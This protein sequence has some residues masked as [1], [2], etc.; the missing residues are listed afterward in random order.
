MGTS[1]RT[2]VDDLR[3]EDRGLQNNAFQYLMNATTGPVD[4]SYEIWDDM[5]QLLQDKDNHLRAI[6]SQVLSNLAKSDPELRI[7][8]DFDALIAVTRDERFVT[9]RHCLQSIWKIG[10]AGDAQRQKV[11]AGLAGRFKECS[12]EKNC[13]LIRYDILEGLRKLYDET[14]D[15]EIKLTAFELIELEDDAKYRKKYQGVWKKK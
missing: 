11:V 1:T 6:A 9:A 7:V 12:A 5:A 3:S 8:R 15:E 10:L 2:A 4:W 13:T 14:N